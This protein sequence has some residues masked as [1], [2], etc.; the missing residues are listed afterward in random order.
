[1]GT[2]FGY[3]NRKNKDQ[4]YL[5]RVFNLVVMVDLVGPGDNEGNE[6]SRRD[7]WSRDSRTSDWDNLKCHGGLDLEV[8]GY[9][10]QMKSN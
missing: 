6:L 8:W 9:R 5:I 4:L 10:T 7:L 1:M 2:S 3:K